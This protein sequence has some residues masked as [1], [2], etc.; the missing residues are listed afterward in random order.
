MS[1]ATMRSQPFAPLSAQHHKVTAQE[2]VLLN[3]VSCLPN[4]MSVFLLN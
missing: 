4:F 3:A 1:L 2:F